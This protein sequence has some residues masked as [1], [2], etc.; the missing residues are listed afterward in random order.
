MNVESD[1][2]L[3]SS[4]KTTNCR[5]TWRARHE[6]GSY[7]RTYMRGCIGS[8]SFQ[9]GF[10]LSPRHACFSAEQFLTFNSSVVL[11]VWNSE[12][13][14]RRLKRDRL[15]PGGCCPFILVHLTNPVWRLA[16]TRRCNRSIAVQVKIWLHL[17]TP[18]RLHALWQRIAA[19]RFASLR[20]TFTPCVALLTL[21]PPFVFCFGFPV[22]LNFPQHYCPRVANTA[23]AY[24]RPTAHESG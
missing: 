21:P 17:G 11:Y 2:V 13:A 3:S 20:R 16:R 1:C 5:S 15:A 19:M 9:T 12:F 4:T 24:L 23:A 14:H 6:I 8:T 18:A 10:S 7:C 22:A